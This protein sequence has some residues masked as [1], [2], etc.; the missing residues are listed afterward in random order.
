MHEDKSADTCIRCH[1]IA[2]CQFK[3]HAV[4]VSVMT[5]MMVLMS[6]AAACTSVS[7]VMIIVVLMLVVVAKVMF[8]CSLQCSKKPQDVAL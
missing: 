8:M 7:M 1:R 4:S 5:F 3:A 6:A 2:L